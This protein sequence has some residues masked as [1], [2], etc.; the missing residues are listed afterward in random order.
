MMWHVINKITFEHFF[1]WVDRLIDCF[2]LCQTYAR[3]P[4]HLIR[5][6]V[7]SIVLFKQDEM[8]LKHIY[9]DHFN[10]DMSFSKFKELCSAC[11][12]NKYGFLVIDKDNEIN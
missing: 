11:W 3:I 9:D 12:D 5:D 10:T 6:N 4:K 1:P 7:N 8:N 2:Y